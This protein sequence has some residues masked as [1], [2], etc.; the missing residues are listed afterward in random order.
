MLCASL[1]NAFIA[2]GQALCAP[3]LF[4]NPRSYAP[5]LTVCNISA[6]GQKAGAAM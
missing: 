5:P 3:V 1:S 4:A 6:K 2:H